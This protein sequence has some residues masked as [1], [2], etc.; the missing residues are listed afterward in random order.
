MEAGAAPLATLALLGRRGWKLEG[1]E[2]L[3]Q[4]SVANYGV[5]ANILLHYG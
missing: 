1:G 2:H 5:K 4:H 3:E